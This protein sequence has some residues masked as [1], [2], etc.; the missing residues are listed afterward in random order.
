MTKTNKMKTKTYRNHRKL[1]K[2]DKMNTTKCD[3]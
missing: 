1:K 3:A 2:L